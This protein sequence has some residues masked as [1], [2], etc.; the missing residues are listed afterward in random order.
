MP[1]IDGEW[2]SV[3]SQVEKLKLDKAPGG[4][5]SQSGLRYQTAR[6]VEPHLEAGVYSFMKTDHGMFFVKEV[7]P[8]D[9]VISLPGLPSEYILEQMK[10]FWSKAEEYRK[11]GLIHKRGILLYGQPGCGKTSIFRLLCNE[12]IKRGGIVFSIDDYEAASF[13][14]T[15][16]RSIEPN[17]PILTIQEDIEGYFDGSAGPAQLKAALSF[18]DGANQTNNIVHLASTNEP[19]K[20]ADRFIKRP[21]RFDLII[22]M[23]AP[24]AETREA[25]LRHVDPSLPEDVLKEM[26]QKTDGLALAYLRELISTHVCLGIPLE[27]T[28]KRLKTDAKKK[29]LKNVNDDGLMGFTL[30]YGQ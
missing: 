29:V 1:W 19:E 21:G 15:E 12:L 13:F 27:E 17:R 24:T 20:L 14:V 30:G 8:T 23:H 6:I 3:Q 16:F 22:G 26:V 9:N 5:V 11:H 7:F 2:V 10:L 25:Y 4:W 18:L 28:V